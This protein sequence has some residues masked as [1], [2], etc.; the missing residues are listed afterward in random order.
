MSKLPVAMQSAITK[1]ENSRDMLTAF[2]DENSKL[3]HEYVNLQDQ[4]NKT[5][6]RV[7]VA[8]KEH[9]DE[10]GPRAGEFVAVPTRT[11][12]ADLLAEYKEDNWPDDLFKT[13][14]EINRDRYKDMVASGMISSDIVA[15]VESVRSISIRGPKSA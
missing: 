3:I 12:D 11:V 8:Y 13:K 9:Y 5:L 10:I 15:E 14:L 1:F 4:Y 7:K 6:E 2:V